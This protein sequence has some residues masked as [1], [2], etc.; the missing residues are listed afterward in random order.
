MLARN[1]LYNSRTRHIDTKYYFSRER[2][3][4]NKL[5]VEYT[6]TAYMVADALTKGVPCLKP[7]NYRHHVGLMILDL[8]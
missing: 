6:P 5:R 2:V 7:E 1:P 8:V 4:S 3:E